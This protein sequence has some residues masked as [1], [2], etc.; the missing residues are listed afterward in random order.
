LPLTVASVVLAVETAV[1]LIVAIVFTV[2]QLLGHRPHDRADAW[3]FVLYSALIG[4]GLAVVTRGVWRRRRW[5][6]APAVLAQLLTLPVGVSAIGVGA[7]FVGVPLLVC[8]A[9]G[10]VGLFAPS[11]TRVFVGD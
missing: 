8:G 11:S 2:Y 3:I 4:S 6:R 1:L 7:W 9:L 10:L 5:S